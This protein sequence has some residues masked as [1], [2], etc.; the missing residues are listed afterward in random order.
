[1]AVVTSLANVL[2]FKLDRQGAPPKDAATIILVRASEGTGASSIELFCVERSKASRFLGG[3]IVFPGGKLDDSDA[4]PEWDEAL[5]TPPRSPAQPLVEPFTRDAAHLRSLAIAAARETLEEAA[6]LHVVGGTVTQDELFD[7]RARLTTDPGALRTFLRE[8]SLRLDLEALYPFA[9]WVTPTAESRRY[10]ARFFLA[11][12]PSNQT[13]AHDEKETMA[14]FWATPSEILRRWEAGEVQIAP[15]T[16]RTIWLLSECK[17]TADVIAL[18]QSSSLEP[19]CPELVKQ[20]D[21]LALTLPGDR[22]HGVNE[23][24][25]RGSSRYVLRGDRW[26]AEDAP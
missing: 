10:D 17:T 12:A 11:I 7:L 26:L 15:P 21:T 6:L 8:R 23:V 5:A 16:H 20:G 3:A 22:E 25:V 4:S 2:D 9:R 19:I 13:G 14:S 24:R 18:A 1:M